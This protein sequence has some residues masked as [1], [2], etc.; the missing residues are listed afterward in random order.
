[1]F[2]YRAVNPPFFRG[3]TLNK[4]TPI[5]VPGSRLVEEEPTVRGR[6]SL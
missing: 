5:L 4:D 1:M 6:C 2:I 3:E